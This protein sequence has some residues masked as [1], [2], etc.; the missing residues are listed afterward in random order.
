MSSCDKSLITVLKHHWSPNRAKLK[1]HKKQWRNVAL[2]GV[3]TFAMK[4]EVSVGMFNL[5]T[6]TMLEILYPMYC[7]MKLDI[8]SNG[9][10]LLQNNP[11]KH[12]K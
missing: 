2:L 5:E 12:E 4:H 10:F 6:P 8:V 1:A 7:Q 11:A 9:R 3:L